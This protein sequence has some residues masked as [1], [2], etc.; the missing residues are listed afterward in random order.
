MR[1]ISSSL[2]PFKLPNDWGQA[3]SVASLAARLRHMRLLRW[4]Q[5]FLLG[6]PGLTACGPDWDALLHVQRSDAGSSAVELDTSAETASGSDAASGGA[7]NS[8]TAS[9][10]ELSGASQLAPSEGADDASLIGSLGSDG[11]LPDAG[12]AE[13][14]EQGAGSVAR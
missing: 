12:P 7:A 14:F 4:L 3:L 5:A 13:S 10:S 6:V 2:T 9:N 8:S 11:G 1:F